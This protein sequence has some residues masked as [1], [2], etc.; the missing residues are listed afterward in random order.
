MPQGGGLLAGPMPPPALLANPMAPPA[1]EAA[2][3][4]RPDPPRGAQLVTLGDRNFRAG[5]VHRAAERYTQAIA[6]D[7]TAAAPRVR[8]AQ[9]ALCRGQFAEA[10]N[11]YRDA[12]IAEPGW[13]IHAPDIQAIYGEP[14]DFA[15]Q[16]A[17]LESH[18]SRPTTTTAT[19]GSSSARSGTCPVRPARPP[20]SSFAS[21]TA[22][23]TPA[24]PPSSTP[25]RPSGRRPSSCRVGTDTPSFLGNGGRCP[26]YV[27]FPEKISWTPQAALS[28][29]LTMIHW[30]LDTSGLV[31]ED[32]L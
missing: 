18:T 7:P 13:L 26:P 6:A 12:M 17:K 27:D 10:A 2:K 25:R 32:A 11:H 9:I 30:F 5:N 19:P 14:A 28:E 15:K 1:G 21:P 4:R 31:E 8:M 23:P 22:R 16:I 29:Q 24:W 20:T 3:P